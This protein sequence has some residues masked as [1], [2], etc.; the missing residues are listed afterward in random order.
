M[1]VVVYRHAAYDTPWWAYPSSRDGRF[2]RAGVDTVQYLCLHP[3]GPAAE[4][5]RHNVGPAGDP[6]DVLLNL[7]SAAV[8]LNGLIRIS[9]DDC[10]SQGITPDELVGDDYTPTQQLAN[11]YR[12]AGAEGLVV[13][14]AALPGT[15]ILVLFGVRLLHPYLWTPRSPEEIPTGHLTDGARAA[16]EVGTL[17]RWIG[18]PHPAL[19]HWKLTGAYERLD[20]PLALR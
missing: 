2:H 20:D 9:F 15:E 13:P 14:S 12:G 4:M 3:L 17:I 19:E 10:E 16:T 5:L 7:W 6:D 8:D 11:R 1:R 18:D